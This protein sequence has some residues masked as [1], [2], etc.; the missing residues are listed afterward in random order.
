VIVVA[1]CTMLLI[2][3]IEETARYNNAAVVIKIT[4]VLVLR[5][6]EPNRPRPFRT[7]WVP[8]VPL[9]GIA[10]CLYLM[11]ALPIDTWA[12]LLV[13]LLVGLVI[14]FVYGRHHSKLN[15][16]RRS[17]GGTHETDGTGALRG[18]PVPSVH[19]AAAR[20]ILPPT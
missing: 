19:H 16:T 12:R 1:L 9:L 7:P 4:V 13:W 20:A 14:Y 3:G 17:L 10:S 8:V 2:V 18:A 11:S 6:K 5:Y 15:K